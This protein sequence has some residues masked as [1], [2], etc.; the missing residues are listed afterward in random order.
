MAELATN[1]L[2]VLFFFGFNPVQ[3][4]ECQL[5]TDCLFCSRETREIVGKLKVWSVSSL[6]QTFIRL[7]SFKGR[8]P[9][10]SRGKSFA[11]LQV[12]MTLYD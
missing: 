3:C 4:L 11:M 7:N 1:T 12:C 10:M 5:E 8:A 6:G 9:W 2:H